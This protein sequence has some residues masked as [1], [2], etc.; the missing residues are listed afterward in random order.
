MDCHLQFVGVDLSV[1]LK[2]SRGR[3]A[4]G[5]GY[6]ESSKAMAVLLPTRVSRRESLLLSALRAETYVI[7]EQYLRVLSAV[8]ANQFLRAIHIDPIGTRLRTNHL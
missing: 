3:E 1:D 5:H 4:K 7:C 2:G 8:F 6:A